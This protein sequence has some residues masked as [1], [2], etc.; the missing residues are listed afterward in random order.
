MSLERWTG[1]SL[2]QLGVLVRSVGFT[3]DAMEANGLKQGK[4]VTRHI[5]QRF[6]W[7]LHEK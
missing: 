3:L 4:G 1:A 5:F 7:L 6:S 2:M